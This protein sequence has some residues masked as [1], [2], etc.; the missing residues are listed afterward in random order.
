M[1][2]L[3]FARGTTTPTYSTSGFDDGCIYF[4][5]STQKIYMRNG[6]SSSSSTVEVYDGN[7]NSTYSKRITI[8]G[9]ASTY[10]GYDMCKIQNRPKEYEASATSGAS[11]TSWYNTFGQ[12]VVTASAL[13]GDSYSSGFDEAMSYHTSV[14][15]LESAAKIVVSVSPFYMAYVG[16]GGSSMTNGAYLPQGCI[17]EC[18]RTTE[19]AYPY[20]E[21]IMSS[22]SCNGP[23]FR[24]TCF[25][26]VTGSGT[27][28]GFGQI[29]LDLCCNGTNAIYASFYACRAG[30][31]TFS[32]S[33]LDCYSAAYCYMDS[34]N[35]YSNI[36]KY[37]Y[38][39][40]I[41]Y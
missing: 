5:T 40:A 39:L 7:N 31:S 34:S 12:G 27:Y 20:T 17:V 2:N 21:D 1:A 37:V 30:S 11:S 32:T 22:Y 9:S 18:Y 28:T 15:P 25:A 33:S 4:N 10:T 36:E 8:G 23:M 24:G 13:A 29:N 6:T 19:S 41:Y 3:K 35:I 14:P 38:P 26:G 16:N